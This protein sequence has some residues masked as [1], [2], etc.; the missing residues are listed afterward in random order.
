MP[1]LEKE[2][3]KARM[4]WVELLKECTTWAA[5]VAEREKHITQLRSIHQENLE[6]KDAFYK[7]RT[8]KV[9]TELQASSNTKLPELYA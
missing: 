4:E 7:A 2:L 1:E 6:R 8:A 5:N 9:A 3:E